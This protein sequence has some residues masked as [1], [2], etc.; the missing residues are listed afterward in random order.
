MKTYESE[1][2]YVKTLRAAIEERLN[3]YEFEGKRIHLPKE[4]IEKILFDIYPFTDAKRIGFN[5]KNIHKLDLSE[6]SFEDV[7]FISFDPEKP[8]NLANTNARIDLSKSWDYKDKSALYLANID[9]RNVDLSNNDFEELTKNK[10]ATIWS[11]NLSNTKLQ[12]TPKVS[13]S[14]INCNLSNNDLIGL[15][16]HLKISDGKYLLSTGLL[17]LTHCNIS[18]TNITLNPS[19]NMLKY[20]LYYLQNDP[21]FTG[22]YLN[23][24]KISPQSMNVN[25][26]EK[27]LVSLDDYDRERIEYT[28]KLIDKQIKK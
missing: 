7:S 11:C 23:G 25:D 26:T 9:L 14:F 22:C 2:N 24:N 16:I 15:I 19:H 18:N 3:G 21:N 13:A 1:K 10:T 27:M 28:L 12:I 5:S 4:D 20:Q 6:V 8:I 17:E